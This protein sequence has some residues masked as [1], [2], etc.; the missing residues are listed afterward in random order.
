MRH[1]FT[2]LCPLAVLL[3]SLWSCASIEPEVG[4]PTD[5]T[6][7]PTVVGSEEFKDPLESYNRVMFRVND[8]LYQWV[9]I[10]VGKGY[11]WLVPTWLQQ[12]FSH[13]FSNLATPVYFVSNLLSG[14]PIH[15]RDNVYRFSVNTTIGLLGL[16]DPADNWLGIKK[17]EQH[18]ED[19]LMGY[20]VG[21]G[22][23]VVLPIIG[24]SDARNSASLVFDFVLN[25]V[26]YYNPENHRYALKSL[27]Y[28]E[29]NHETL[30]QYPKLHKQAEDPYLYFRNM[31][32]QGKIRD[33]QYGE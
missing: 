2:R 30:K 11:D 23:F 6:P 28:V 10:P 13:F 18:L 14:E 1:R 27:N 22:T 12:R 15:A 20:G 7:A 9:F 17:Q 21:Y 5:S 8:G 31:Y 33:Q 3:L 16:F 4:G 25:P 24:P 32:L 29:D 26:T 19:A